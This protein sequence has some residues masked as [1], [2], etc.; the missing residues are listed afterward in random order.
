MIGAVK[1][2]AVELLLNHL[3]DLSI[4]NYLMALK[5]SIIARLYC[6]KLNW[7]TWSEVVM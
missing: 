5:T 6:L 2:F 1:R 4:L 7:S 3:I